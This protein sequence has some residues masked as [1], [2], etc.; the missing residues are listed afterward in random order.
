MYLH[1]GICD[2]YLLDVHSVNILP[3]FIMWL[4]FYVLCAVRAIVR[5]VYFY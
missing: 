1:F 5:V 2:T 3:S 4:H